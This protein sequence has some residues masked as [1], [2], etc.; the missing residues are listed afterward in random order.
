MIYAVNIV[1]STLQNITQRKMKAKRTQTARLSF[2]TTE[3]RLTD[4]PGKHFCNF[5]SQT[6]QCKNFLFCTGNEF[7]QIKL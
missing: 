3:T 5:L 2:Y 7:L 6:S 4:A 1:I